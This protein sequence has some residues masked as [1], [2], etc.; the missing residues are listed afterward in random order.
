MP[1]LLRAKHTTGKGWAIVGVLFSIASALLA[2]ADLLTQA[3]QVP[4]T[5]LAPGRLL[6]ALA[7]CLLGIALSCVWSGRLLAG[8][9]ARVRDAA[10]LLNEHTSFAAAADR[11]S[12]HDRYGQPATLYSTE[13]VSIQH[14]S[15]G[16]PIASDPLFGFAQPTVGERCFVLPREGEPLV[17]CQDRY[18]LNAARGCYAVAD[19]V[20]GSFLP[21]P[22]ASITA[23]R[24]VERVE[25]FSE[26]EAFQHWLHECCAEWQAWMQQR[27]VPAMNSLRQL[28]GEQPG[29]WNEEIVKGAQ[30][31]LAGCVIAPLNAAGLIDIQVWAIGDTQF[32]LFHRGIDGLWMMQTAFPLTHP[33]QFGYKPDTLFTIVHPNLFEQTWMARKTLRC[34]ALPG[35]Y[36][37]LATDTVGKWMLSQTR[38][39]SDKLT[40]LLH[41]ASVEEFST[42]LHEELRAK[43]I[44]ED[45]DMTMLVIPL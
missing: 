14:G 24:F 19:G 20:S 22:W 38:Y 5:G 40:A 44:E 1:A 15:P 33:A 12:A 29:D 23:Q 9:H 7:V 35:D 30:T 43:H 28:Q 31:T 45:D 3:M 26:K 6:F 36:V 11:V 13:E 25:A 16:V 8:S 42:I 32:F 4:A 39:P 41:S 37:V 21:G 2:G 27:W 34:S 10:P 17:E 18:A